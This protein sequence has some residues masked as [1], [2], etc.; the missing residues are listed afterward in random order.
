[1]SVDDEDRRDGGVIASSNNN[2][3][4]DDGA[5]EVDD[6]LSTFG[7]DAEEA[8]A[9]GDQGSTTRRGRTA[10]TAMAEAR[11]YHRFILC[12]LFG[13]L[14]VSAIVASVRFYSSGPSSGRV[15]SQQ[16]EDEGEG[17]MS[18]SNSNNEDEFIESF[19]GNGL[20]DNENEERMQRTLEFLISTSAS[21]S[22]TLSQGYTSIGIIDIDV[23]EA[24]LTAMTDGTYTPQYSA[25]VWM[26]KYDK[27]VLEVPSANL[28][29]F[30]STRDASIE[31]PFLQRYSL[32]VLYFALSG[33]SMWVHKVNF[34]RDFHECGWSDAFFIDNGGGMEIEAYGT[35]CDGFPDYDIDDIESNWDMWN[36]TRTITDIRLPPL[37]N[38]T[39]TFP[40]ELRHLRYLK[41]LEVEKNFGLTGGIPTEYGY[42]KNLQVLALIENGLTGVIP[43]TF[44]FLTKMQY[45]DLNHNNFTADTTKGDLDFL[46]EMTSLKMLTLDYNSGIVGTLPS[47]VSNMSALYLLSL[48]NMALNGALPSELSSLMN[49]ESLYL[50]DNAFT[51]SLDVVQEMT[52]LRHVYLEDNMWTGVI[53]D[54]FFINLIN[55]VHLD[56]SN[57]SLKGT[58][59]GHLF[60]TRS[61]E[62][63]DLSDNELTGMLPESAML[64]HGGGNLTYLSLHTNNIT[65]SIPSSI[66]DLTLLRTLDLSRNQFTGT[67]PSEIGNLP[68]IQVLFLGKNNFTSGPIPKWIKNLMP[69]SELSLKGSSLT[70]E[71][72][73]WLGNLDELLLLDLG[74]NE[75]NG[76]I[77]QELGNLIQLVVLIL[78]SNKL[79]GKLGLGELR[80][81]EV[82]LLDDNELTGDTNDMCEHEIEFFTSDCSEDAPTGAE[83]DC[84]CCTLCCADENVTCNDAE[85]MANHEGIWETQY[86][87]IFWNFE[88][89]SISPYIDYDTST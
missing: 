5:T 38:L 58:V 34:L 10:A 48:S 44:S 25:A 85:W 75:L 36:G 56:I 78:N 32:A 83:I 73:E 9:A 4:V 43:R 55:L 45:L 50:D 52:N 24:E 27:M 47:I 63:L 1:M 60:R 86:Q 18:N 77:P 6:G 61:L 88:D 82:L 72:P 26:A 80:N 81:L 74:E 16:G 11:R 87:R 21:D 12:L 20:D 84:K 19:V 46:A 49:L 13:T 40:P 66:G 14:F 69:L 22:S 33:P 31:Y 65:G 41:W 71:I 42:L 17:P 29:G 28:D 70:G 3:D 57:C 23:D 39:G 67:L 30:V 53:D 62:I 35:M 15:S 2:D 59:P 76:T 79:T 68:N 89:K 54:S 7:G 8:G 37:N 51:G 64:D